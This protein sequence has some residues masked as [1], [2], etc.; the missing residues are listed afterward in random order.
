LISHI[1]EDT[2][3]ILLQKLSSQAITMWKLMVRI[4]L[5]NKVICLCNITLPLQPCWQNITGCATNARGMPYPALHTSLFYS[6]RNVVT[7]FC[8]FPWKLISLSIRFVFVR[9][10]FLSSTCWLLN[11]CVGIQYTQSTSSI[12]LIM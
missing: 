8:T 1:F 7:T 12:F 9:D 3:I 2:V 10:L 5:N 6:K 11:N 4:L